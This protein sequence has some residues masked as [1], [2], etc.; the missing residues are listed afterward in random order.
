MMLSQL[1]TELQQRKNPEKAKVLQR[2]FKTGPGQYGEGDVFLGITVPEQRKI[3]KKYVNISL[4]ELSKSI[5]SKYHEV[6][7]T[8]FIILTYKFEKAT[9][10]EQKEIF[11]FYINHKQYA[12]NWDLIDVTAHKVIGRYL[13]DKDKSLLHALA[14]SDNLW[15]R[16]ISILA[17]FWFIH[18]NQFT[19]SLEIAEILVNDKHDLIHKAVGWMLREIGKRDQ[20]LEEQFLQQHYKTMPRTM[21]RYA[22]EKFS[23]EKRAYY[24]QK[25]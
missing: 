17:T 19:D 9:P 4:A 11:D 5:K 7:L 16:R 12:N 8:S 23:S 1:L 20:P 3:A 6:R 13:L 24:M 25:S 15:D 2:F 10:E 18:K 22:I 21:L 14:Q